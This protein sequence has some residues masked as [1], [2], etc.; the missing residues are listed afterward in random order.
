MGVGRLLGRAVPA[1]VRLDDHAGV[2]L[3]EGV[4]SAQRLQGP[5]DQG[6]VLFPL[7]HRQQRI[8]LGLLLSGEDGGNV[9]NGR[10]HAQP[11]RP[12]RDLLEKLPAIH[13]RSPVASCD[14]TKHPSFS[15]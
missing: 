8:A 2:F 6:A 10:G 7:G 4:D 1:D 13:E 12:G 14:E 9:E 3:D 11:R 5:L 15:S